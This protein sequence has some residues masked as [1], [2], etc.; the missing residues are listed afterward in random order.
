MG[1]Y[2]LP[3]LAVLLI[4]VAT[5][6]IGLSV[7]RLVRRH[8]TL[9]S[10][11]ASCD[12]VAEPGE[13]IEVRAW[14]QPRGAVRPTVEVSLICTL[15]DHQAHRLWERTVEMYHRD[16]DRYTADLVIPSSA[17]G[18]GVVGNDLSLLFSEEARR[19]LVLWSVVVTVRSEG[20]ATLARRVLPLEVRGGRTLAA[21]P[22]AISRLVVGAFA[23]VRDDLLFNWLVKVASRDG[24]VSPRERDLLREVL[25]AS[26]G[27]DDVAAADDRIAAELE[28]EAAMEGTLIRRHVPAAARLAFCRLLYTVAWRDGAMHED[29]QSYLSDRLCDLG[30]S[31]SEVRSVEREVIREIA[32]Q[33]LA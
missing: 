18:S 5:V 23:E 15:F 11:H 1:I 20:G 24:T 30:L 7:F 9:R 33:A 27:V 32:Q 8:R 12:P 31:R 14:V 22:A 10:F 28:R 3:L 26:Q 17:P 4:G 25:R 13:A 21:D 2:L 29:E 19:L 16:A 6:A